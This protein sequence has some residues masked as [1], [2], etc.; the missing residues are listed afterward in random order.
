MRKLILLLSLF[1]PVLSIAQ[2]LTEKKAVRIY[3]HHSSSINGNKQFGAGANGDS[4]GY[5]FVKHTYY[6]SFH[7]TLG[8][9]WSASELENIDMVEHN[10]KFGNNGPFGITSGVSTIWS[11]DIKGNGTTMYM[12]A[13]VTFNYATSTK[14]TDIK[15]AFDSAKATVAIGAV[16]NGK[17]YLARIRKGNQYVAMRITN[18]L[19]LPPNFNMGNADVY[20]DFDYKYGTYDPTGVN[21][22]TT[23]VKT[24]TINPNPARGSFKISLPA[25]LNAANTAITIINVTGQVVL[26]GKYEDNY[27][28]HNLMP[29]NYIVRLTDGM[30]TCQSRLV[31]SE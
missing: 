20:F 2:Q 25:T 28:E 14:V 9:Q 5:D 3:E 24:F 31:I 26:S 15:N 10:G 29:G 6:G 30:T 17:I 19:N 22:V 4:S 11:G 13:P 16:T 12:E 18:V 7:P 1:T 23:A 8:K 21:D 27:M